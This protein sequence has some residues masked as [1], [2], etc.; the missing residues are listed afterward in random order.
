MLFQ[1][2]TVTKIIDEIIIIGSTEHLVALDNVGM[3]QMLENRDF[4][5]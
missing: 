3:M 2:L 1:I 5:C 4:V